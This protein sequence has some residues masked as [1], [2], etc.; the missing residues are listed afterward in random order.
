MSTFQ[1]VQNRMNDYDRYI[2][3]FV[4]VYT[5]TRKKEPWLSKI[6][7]W[8]TTYLSA[9]MKR[10]IKKNRFEDENKGNPERRHWIAVSRMCVCGERGDWRTVQ[11]DRKDNGGWP[12]W[13]YQKVLSNRGRVVRWKYVQHFSLPWPVFFSLQDFKNGFFFLLGYILKGRPPL[14]S[15]PANGRQSGL[16]FDCRGKRETPLW[17]RDFFFLSVLSPPSTYTGAFRDWR[18]TRHLRTRLYLCRTIHS[19][20]V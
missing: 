10:W 20:G 2:L 12:P 17:E 5:H 19:D 18:R 4:I 9:K 6:Y 16:P 1:R 11:L 8:M 7:Q 3:S 15:W 14:S 13:K